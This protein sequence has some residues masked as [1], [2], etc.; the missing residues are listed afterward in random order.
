MGKTL[1]VKGD[2]ISS[3]ARATGKPGHRVAL[4][5][6]CSVLTAHDQ[7]PRV[8]SQLF[9]VPTAPLICFCSALLP[10]SLFLCTGL[11]ECGG[12]EPVQEY[13][14]AASRSRG[15]SRLSSH[16]PGI[17]E[18]PATGQAFWAVNEKD[19]VLPSGAESPAPI[20][21]CKTNH[22]A[23]PLCIPE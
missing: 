16:S 9:L 17:W 21:P 15:G 18:A 13:H 20:A 7:V 19:N 14:P 6:L 12:Q 3:H 5:R 1:R 4:S 22:T 10:L 8:H 11:Q 23:V 2:I